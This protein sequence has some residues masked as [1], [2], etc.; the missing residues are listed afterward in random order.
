MLRLYY[1]DAFIPCRANDRKDR[2]IGGET[3][4]EIISSLVLVLCVVILEIPTRN[5]AN[6][7]TRAKF[8]SD[9]GLAFF[10]SCGKFEWIIRKL[11]YLRRVPNDKWEGSHWDF[12]HLLRTH[13][14][15]KVSRLKTRHFRIFHTK[16]VRYVRLNNNVFFRVKLFAIS[17]YIRPRIIPNVFRMLSLSLWATHP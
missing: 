1:L 15:R 5:C 16:I 14:P 3:F 4:L 9:R 6:A 8:P 2:E 10:L 13:R 7:E 11:M 17:H 12:C